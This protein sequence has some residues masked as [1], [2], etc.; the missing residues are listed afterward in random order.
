M[1]SEASSGGVVMVIVK[2]KQDLGIVGLAAAAA[3]P[4]LII[5]SVLFCA[6]LEL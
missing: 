1:G 3:G 6:C 2:T 5:D 4:V